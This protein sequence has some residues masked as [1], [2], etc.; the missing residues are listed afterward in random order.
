M[1]LQVFAHISICY[2]YSKCL[3]F[4]ATSI[5]DDIIALSSMSSFLCVFFFFFLFLCFRSS[6][7]FVFFTSFNIYLFTCP[8]LRPRVLP[9][10]CPVHENLLVNYTK[11]CTIF[12]LTTKTSRTKKKKKK[13]KKR[14]RCTTLKI[15]ASVRQYPYWKKITSVRPFSLSLSFAS[16]NS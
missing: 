3:L 15:L 2:C 1:N 7:S 16:P 9:S 12:V 10:G 4:F 8:F 14:V 5:H 13:K 11:A 6:F